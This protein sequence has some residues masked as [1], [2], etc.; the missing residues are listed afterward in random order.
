MIKKT[1]LHQKEDNLKKLSF[2]LVF[3]LVFISSDSMSMNLFGSNSSVL[4]QFVYLLTFLFFLIR[5][6]FYKTYNRDNVYIALL[7]IVIFL[8]MFFNLDFS[9]GYIVQ[10]ISLIFGYFFVR[11]VPFQKFATTYT[12]VVYYLALLSLIL[13][14]LFLL[15]PQ[16]TNFFTINLNRADTRYINLFFYIHFVDMFRNT[17]IFREPGVYIIYLN[18]AVFIE[19]FFKKTPNRKYLVVFII[20][21]LTTL[22]TAGF[23]ILGLIGLIYTLKNKSAKTISQV[24][25]VFILVVSFIIYNFELF[26]TTLLKFETK[27][28]GFS[29]ALAR[30]SSFWIP[31]NIFVDSPFLGVGLSKFT[32]L[33]EIYSSSMYGII[34][35]SGG[36]S[37]NT[38]MNQ[39]ATYGLIS[40]TIMSIGFF[41]LTAFFSK[42]HLLRFLIFIAFLLL[43]SNED[44]RFSLL[45]STLLFYGLNN[46][47]VKDFN[48]FTHQL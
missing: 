24:V 48:N 2:I 38:L 17:G 33:Y 5:R 26:E 12:K 42:S 6:N 35:K 43:L 31:F 47:N 29:G 19:L 45:F 20:A 23:I 21:I 28:S 14:S 36:H 13:F 10:M 32:D 44:I 25:F 8:T 37:T 11:K 1:Y 9:F 30:T 4:M 16:T 27:D 41:K 18:I 3:I 40:A 39:L 15:F 46:K 7:L 22:S 34:L